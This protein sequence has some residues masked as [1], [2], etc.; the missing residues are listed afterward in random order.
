MSGPGHACQKND[1]LANGPFD[2]F[3][4]FN[5]GFLLQIA[6][7]LNK[8]ERGFRRENLAPHLFGLCF[9]FRQVSIQLVFRNALATVKLRNTAPNFCVDCVSIVDKPSILFLLRFRCNNASSALAEPVAC[10]CF[11]MLAPSAASWIS[12]CIVRSALLSRHLSQDRPERYLSAI[13]TANR[14]KILVVR[15]QFLTARK[16]SVAEP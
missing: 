14:R 13:G 2:P 10:I 12:M 8:I 3:G 5:T 1:L 7:D 11:C 9:L 16:G 6:P 4:N 15:I